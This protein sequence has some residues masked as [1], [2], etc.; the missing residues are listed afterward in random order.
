[1]GLLRGE[2]REGDQAQSDRDEPGADQALAGGAQHEG[3]DHEGRKQTGRQ[4]EEVVERAAGV[5]DVAEC[6]PLRQGR[7]KLRIGHNREVHRGGGQEGSRGHQEERGSREGGE[8]AGADQ[9]A[10]EEEGR[11]EQGEHRSFGER[12]DRRAE[13]R[14]GEPARGPGPPDEAHLDTQVGEGRRRDEEGLQLSGS[15]HRE[16]AMAQQQ[17]ASGSQAGSGPRGTQ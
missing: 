10:G 17:E 4:P 14:D 16:E 15:R 6:G 8:A 12:G 9:V 2:G 11:K 3:E 5:L 1:M 13:T 7:P